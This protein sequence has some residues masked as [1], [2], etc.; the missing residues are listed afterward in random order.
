MKKTNEDLA[1]QMHTLSLEI[2]QK[3]EKTSDASKEKLETQELHKHD[4]KLTS[5]ETQLLVMKTKQSM[6]HNG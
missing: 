6:Y 3:H 4:S 2:K 5:A 1:Y